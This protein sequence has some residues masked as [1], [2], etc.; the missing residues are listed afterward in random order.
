VRPLRPEGAARD[1]R[2]AFRLAAVERDLVDLFLVGAAA[3]K[4]DPTIVGRPR[5]VTVAFTARQLPYP[6]A[7]DV[8]Q[9]EIVEIRI[10][11]AVELC[12]DEHNL[13]AVVRDLRRRHERQL[14]QV[15]RRH[16]TRRGDDRRRGTGDRGRR[17][18]GEDQ[19]PRLDVHACSLQEMMPT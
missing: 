19:T 6:A 16:R 17:D 8:G 5:R 7:A 14:E 4:G 11:R 18:N 13:L 2:E 9:P 15:F 3:V 10:F 1:V 12:H